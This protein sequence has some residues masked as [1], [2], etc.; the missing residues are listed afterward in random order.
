MSFGR[1]TKMVDGASLMPSFKPS[2]TIDTFLLI[3]NKAP[4]FDDTNKMLL[5][6]KAKKLVHQFRAKK[7]CAASF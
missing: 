3:Q 1:K 7:I 5:I 6:K 4:L 2:D